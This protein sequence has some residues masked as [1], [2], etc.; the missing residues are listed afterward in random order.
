MRWT[1]AARRLQRAA[2]LKWAAIPAAVVS[3]GIA[4]AQ[5]W[6][7][8]ASRS[9]FGPHPDEAVAAGQD[10]GPAAPFREDGPPVRRTPAA[11]PSDAGQ[12][13]HSGFPGAPGDPAR[14]RQ[15]G[16]GGSTRG[17]AMDEPALPAPPRRATGHRGRGTAHGLHRGPASGGGRI[18]SAAPHSRAGV[19]AH[20]RNGCSGYAAPT[21]YAGPRRPNVDATRVE[22]GDRGVADLTRMMRLAKGSASSS[23]NARTLR[24]QQGEPKSK[25]EPRNTEVDEDRESDDGEPD[26]DD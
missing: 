3:G 23:F 26:E 13:R 19:A 4:A 17:A 8:A 10:V 22:L 11:Y 2:L 25:N 14:P 5:P 15:S 12:D 20:P 1:K 18:D 7:T 21:G 24:A 16:S 9:S 6:D